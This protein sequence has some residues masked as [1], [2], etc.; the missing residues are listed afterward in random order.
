MPLD[1]GRASRACTACR[2]QKTR[3]YESARDLAC[4][5]CKH[6]GQWCSL[7]LDSTAS[8]V[9]HDHQLS[10]ADVTQHQD[11]ARYLTPSQLAFHLVIKEDL[12][13]WRDSSRDCRAGSRNWRPKPQDLVTNSQCKCVVRNSSAGLQYLIRNLR[14]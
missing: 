8:A 4:L 13:V 3:C 6:I 9:R 10:N 5:R 7:E 14:H 12:S 1:R 2:K 11:D